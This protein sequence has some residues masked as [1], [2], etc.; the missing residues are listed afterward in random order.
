MTVDVTL[1]LFKKL[2]YWRGRGAS[3]VICAVSCARWQWLVRK[4]Y[5]NERS[6]ISNRRSFTRELNT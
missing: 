6:R 4:A 2:R 5:V 3:F 1:R